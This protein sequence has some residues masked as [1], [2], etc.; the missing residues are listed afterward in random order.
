MFLFLLILHFNYQII[1]TKNKI[2]FYFK[3][4]G[5]LLIFSMIFNANKPFQ[6]QGKEVFAQPCCEEF[7]LKI[8]QKTSREYMV[9]TSEKILRII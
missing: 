4:E 8:I 1:I 9:T 7:L 2:V 6:W 5:S 3:G